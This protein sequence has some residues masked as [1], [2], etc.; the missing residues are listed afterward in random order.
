MAKYSN[1][2]KL[3]VVQYYSSNY[4]RFKVVSFHSISAS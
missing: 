1:D 2:L 4:I 3:K